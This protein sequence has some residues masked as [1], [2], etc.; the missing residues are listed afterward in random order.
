MRDALGGTVVLMIIVVFIVFALGYLAF[1]VNYTKA[2]RMKN[3]I[4]SVYEDYKGDCSSSECQ[5]TIADYAKTIGYTVD[6][7]MHCPTGFEK[8]KGLYCAREQITDT[9][10]SQSS[11][12]YI[13]KSG[14]SGV[15]LS[16]IKT[17]HYYT[18][19]TKINLQIPV[20]NNIIDFQF[21]YVSGDTKTF[22][23]T[24]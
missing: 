1:N 10:K 19:V 11:I 15:A 24:N 12:S 9:D 14:G 13:K 8:I 21:F 2:F 3:K 23:V 22:E 17:K 18:I 6:T 5:N 4:I 16:D 20:V 7:S